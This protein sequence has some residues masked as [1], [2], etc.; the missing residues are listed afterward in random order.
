MAWG[1]DD[2]LR[3]IKV[4]IDAD[5]LRRLP[6]PLQGIHGDVAEVLDDLRES[7]DRAMTVPAPDRADEIAT[8]R[9]AV[10]EELDS[11]APQRELLEIIRQEIGED[12]I[13]VSDLTQLYFAAH[14]VFPVYRPRTYIHPSYQGT[15]GHAAASALG[16]QVAAEG[17]PVVG[18]AGDGGF[19]FTVQELATAM[20]HGIP[21]TFLVMNNGVFENVERILRN[22]YDDRV[23]CADLR[24][25]D[26]VKLAESFGMPGRRANSPDTL[27]TALKES[28]AES[29]PTLIEYQATAF[30][31]P[32]PLHFRKKVR[33]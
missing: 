12:G 13:L 20:Q 24:N 5:E 17:R 31:S 1:R 30:P 27:R 33:G 29:G 25:P 32:W 2:D 9:A 28:I 8:V 14:D 23:I 18:L 11:V 6:P 19:M 15:L 10:N 7:L 22:D 21:A 26:F 16:A 3:I 4:D